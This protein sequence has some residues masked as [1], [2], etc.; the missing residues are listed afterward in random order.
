M[1]LKW[2]WSK[3]TH[4]CCQLALFLA[5]ATCCSSKVH[6]GVPLPT[7][8]PTIVACKMEAQ[9]EYAHLACT[10]SHIWL[11]FVCLSWC[12]LANF[13]RRSSVGSLLRVRCWWGRSPP[14][15]QYK[16]ITKSLH[17]DVLQRFYCFLKCWLL[18][19]LPPNL[20]YLTNGLKRSLFWEKLLLYLTI[21]KS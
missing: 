18:F 5:L 11:R 16:V 15:G 1:Q 2:S 21:A 13:L 17:L 19:S 4:Q 14:P 9:S 6:L 10:F 8:P 12:L 3:L 7:Q 20:N